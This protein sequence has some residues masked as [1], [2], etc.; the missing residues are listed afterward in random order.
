[1]SL[2]KYNEIDR[3]MNVKQISPRQLILEIRPFLDQ[4]IPLAIAGAGLMLIIGSIKEYGPQSYY[5][6]TYVFGAFM[7]FWGVLYL[8]VGPKFSKTF[9]DLDTGKMEVTHKQ[10]IRMLVKRFITIRAIEQIRI[11]ERQKKRAKRPQYRL[12]VKLEEDWVPI[13]HWSNKDLNSFQEAARSLK[14][15][16]NASKKEFGAS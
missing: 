12:A 1:M 6:F 13:S 4:L 11:E 15:F 3:I 16:I 7:A 2:K 14:G 8:V 9:L 10:G 5:R